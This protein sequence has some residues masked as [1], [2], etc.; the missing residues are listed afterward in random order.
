MGNY[1]VR[2]DGLLTAWQVNAARLMFQGKTDD[3]IIQ[4][5]F[6]PF[7]EIDKKKR[8]RGM[9]KLQKLRKTPAFQEY[10]KSIVTEWSVHN[11]GRALTKLSAQIDDSNGW[12]ANKAANDVLAQAKKFA[13]GE[14]ENT[15]TVK[16]EGMPELGS[17]ENEEQNNAA[18]SDNVQANG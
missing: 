11:I 18:S 13:L 8:A 3:Q 17:P 9:S 4:E 6:Y 5:L 2:R 15:I 7:E 16:V 10:Y 14:D 12:L 1:K